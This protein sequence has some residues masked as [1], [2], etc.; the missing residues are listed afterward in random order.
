MNAVKLPPARRTHRAGWLCRRKI[1]RRSARQ[2]GFGDELIQL[3]E[4]H[5]IVRPRHQTPLEFSNSLSFLPTEV[6]D[7]PVRRLT[8]I[9]YRIRYGQQEIDV[10]GQQEAIVRG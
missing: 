8:Q 9:F 4:K 10:E 3:L 5:R 7:V 2:L 1:S 6:Y